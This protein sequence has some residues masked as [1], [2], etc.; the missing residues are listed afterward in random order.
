MYYAPVSLMELILWRNWKE[1]NIARDGYIFS[2]MVEQY[3]LSNCSE[4][5]WKGASG[6]HNLR[7]EL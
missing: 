7:A 6:S 4:L 5:F 1:N 3:G 2:N